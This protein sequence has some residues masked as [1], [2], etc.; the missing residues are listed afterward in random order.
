MLVLIAASILNHT[1]TVNESTEDKGT[2]ASV[3]LNAVLGY[4]LRP[5]HNAMP[6]YAMFD[7]LY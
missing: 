3:V 6:I 4:S 2:G 5:N 1:A 7:D